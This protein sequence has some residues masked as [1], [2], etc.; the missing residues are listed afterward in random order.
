MSSMGSGRLLTPVFKRGVTLNIPQGYLWSLTV[1]D[2]H[3][4]YIDGL[5]D[6]EVNRYMVAV[7]QKTQ[8]D[9]TVRAF[10][11][12]DELAPDAVLFGIFHKNSARHCGTVRLH[13]VNLTDRTAD[14]GICVFDKRVWGQAIGAAAIGSVTQ[15]AFDRLGIQS[16]LAGTY[17]DN[18]SSWKA[19]MKAGYVLEK[20]VA[21]RYQRDGQPAVVRMLV[22]RRAQ[23]R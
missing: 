10:V 5:N 7:R 4:G 13:H 16:I 6:P 9:D 20:D 23:S 15:W 18:V 12:I 21:D 22:A 1:D 14:I 19:F 3:A 8:T 2:V 11:R 17:V